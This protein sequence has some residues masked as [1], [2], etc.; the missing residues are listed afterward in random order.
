MVCPLRLFPCF[1]ESPCR[2]YRLKLRRAL[3]LEQFGKQECKI[4][5]LL[6]V[7]ARIADRV[8]PVVEIGFCDGTRA[9][10]TFSHILARHL[11]VNAAGVTAL[12]LM[13]L[14]KSA[15][16]VEDQVERTSLVSGGR[17][18]RV[19]MHRIA[20]PQHDSSFTLDRTD[21]RRQKI[22]DLFGT[23]AANQRQPARFV[24]GIED[25][26]QSEKIVSLQ[27]RTALQSDRIFNSARIF[28]MRVVMLTC[29]IANPNHMA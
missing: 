19:S 14:E 25:I 26:D 20:G 21:E 3:F 29:P 4:N 22:T 28:D 9:A 11:K 6:C 7:K 8:I 2:R 27:C 15:D 1:S 17:R 16:L 10:G 24:V 13:H 23:E 18:N 5:R 12:G